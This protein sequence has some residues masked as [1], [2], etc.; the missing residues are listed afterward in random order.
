V[1]PEVWKDVR[2][3]G[4]RY[5]VSSHGRVFDGRLFYGEGTGYMKPWSGMYLRVHLHKPGKSELWSVHRLVAVAFCQGRRRWLIVN[6]KDGNKH[7]NHSDNLEW[8][9][10]RRNNE[11]A[12][13]RGLMSHGEDHPKSKLK[14]SDIPVILDRLAVGERQTDIARCYGVTKQAIRYIKTGKTWRHIAREAA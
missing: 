9:T 13:E 4:R 6:H 11:H 14:E 5:K 3:F 8:V 7:N 10:S 2:G 12:A 1:S